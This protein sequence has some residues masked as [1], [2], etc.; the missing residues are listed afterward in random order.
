MNVIKHRQ[1]IL[2]THEAC[3]QSLQS[4]QCLLLRKYVYFWRLWGARV[5]RVQRQRAVPS[6]SQCPLD[7]HNQ[8]DS[9][10][11]TPSG[12]KT[13]RWATIWL[14]DSANR[15]QHHQVHRLSPGKQ[16]ACKILQ[17]T[18]PAKSLDMKDF[19]MFDVIS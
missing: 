5:G 16:M 19:V 10:Q 9:V 2:S 8:T 4:K 1:S 6:L 12:E 17:N 3:A 11:L 15:S 18:L 13:F 14:I 7:E